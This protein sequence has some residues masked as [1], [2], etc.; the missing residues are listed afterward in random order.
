MQTETSKIT[1]K[2]Q[3]T[4]PKN[5]RNYLDLHAGDEEAYRNL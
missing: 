1:K 4:I 2:Y 5:V 3:A